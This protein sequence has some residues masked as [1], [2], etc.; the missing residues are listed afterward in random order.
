MTEHFILNNCLH[1]CINFAGW[2]AV[3]HGWPLL[4]GSGWLAGWLAG[5]AAAA[6]VG[7]AAAAAAVV[8]LAAAAAA[9]AF[10]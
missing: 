6:A 7:A 9:V 2:V 8:V 1:S 4:V 10:V 3:H 5:A